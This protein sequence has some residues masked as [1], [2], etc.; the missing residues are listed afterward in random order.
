MV[1]SSPVHWNESLVWFEVSGFCDI[2]NIGSSPG[3]LLVIILLLP[4]VVKQESCPCP[5]RAAVLGTVGP[6][7]GLGSTVGRQGGMADPAPRV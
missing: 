5:S 7:P 1:C 2:I 6:A 3:F 4:C